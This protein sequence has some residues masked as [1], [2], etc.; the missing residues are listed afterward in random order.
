MMNTINDSKGLKDLINRNINDYLNNSRYSKLSF[1]IVVS[2]DSLTD[3][4]TITYSSDSLT[5][6]SLSNI[7]NQVLS[8]GDNIIILQY[9]ITQENAYIIADL[10]KLANGTSGSFTTNDGKTITVTN[11]HI[12]SIA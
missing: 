4:A 9:G 8:A 3:I 7:S 6:I 11:G 12:T 2:Y 1:G 5:E 10:T